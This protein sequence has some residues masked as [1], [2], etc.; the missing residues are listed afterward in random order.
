M[1]KAAGCKLINELKLLGMSALRAP[2]VKRGSIEM[3]GWA[4]IYETTSDVRTTICL[5]DKE[6]W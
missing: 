2:C 1:L 6:K 3:G 4:M 5:G